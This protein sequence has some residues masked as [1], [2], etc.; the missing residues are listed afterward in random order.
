MIKIETLKLVVM[1]SGDI[2]SRTTPSFCR[3]RSLFVLPLDGRHAPRGFR[4]Y[5]VIS[6]NDDDKSSLFPACSSRYGR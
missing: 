6:R 4:G 1:Y 2:F 5:V 3:L